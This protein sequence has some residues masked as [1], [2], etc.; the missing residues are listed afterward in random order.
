[1][2]KLTV[3]DLIQ[4]KEQQ[5]ET[6]ALRTGIAAGEHKHIMLCAGTACVSLKSRSIKHV[7]E[8]EL[9]RH[10]LDKKITV[11]LTG[12]NG[13]CA[14]GPVM[15]VMPDGIFY[16]SITEEDIPYLIEQHFVKGKPVE[17]HQYHPPGKKEAVAGMKDID[18]F[19]HQTLV[20]LKNKGHID[21]ERIEDYIAFDGYRALVKALTEMTPGQVI[22]QIQDSGLRGRGGGG[23]PT[24][25]KWASAAKAAGKPK[26]IICNADEGD[27]GAYM[28]RSIIE[29][30]PH[31]VIEGMLINAYAIGAAT[32]F[33]YIRTE[34][35]LACERLDIAIKQARDCGLLGEN[36]LGNHFNFDI[37][38]KQGSGA[39]VCGESSALR[40]SIEGRVGEPTPKYDHA[41][42]KGLWQKPT[43]LNNVETYANVPGI[44]LNGAQWFAAMGTEKS[45]GTK[46]FSLVGNIENTGLIEVQMGTTLRQ[47]IYDIGGGVPDGKKLKAVQTGGPSGGCIPESMLDMPVD[48]DELT[49][50][51]SM[52]GSGGMIA[53][54]ENSCMVNVARYFIEFCND[55]SCGKCT[56]CRDGS[57]ALLE[58]LD[59]IIEG[60]GKEDDLSLLD[61]LSHAIIEG[62]LCGLGTSLPNPVL[63]T[64][65]YFREEYEEHI[66]DKKCR[67]GVCK[68]L[69]HYKVNEETCKQCGVCFNNCPVGA[70][71]WEKKASAVINRQQ[72]TKCGIC[73]KAC[74]FKTIDIV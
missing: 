56:T 70:I 6:V 22:R 62:S 30:D 16:H 8:K 37:H 31:A 68:K 59:R 38:I 24:G 28:D 29:A 14:V 55:E 49:K 74:K 19:A 17:K 34:Y 23:F 63:S 60:N 27:P 50:A 71:T 61:E 41:V 73:Y 35:P 67:A 53:L 20:A 9:V 1:M 57:E 40:A 65:K 43:V 3:A 2:Q 52:M 44:I 7:A 46:V 48:F 64:L 66:G 12:C 4:I 32:G 47:I 10:G 36:I 18:F 69:F 54:D 5:K 11:I 42:D 13:F 58:I 15:T 51:G 25:R 21:P 45:K 72:C 26:Y 39:F 33:V